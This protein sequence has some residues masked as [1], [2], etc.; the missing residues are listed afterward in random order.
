M[1][2]ERCLG[3]DLGG[4]HL[5]AV[6]LG[7][8]GGV[9][10]VRQVPCPLWQGLD[11]LESAID[12]VLE[13][14]PDRATRHAVTMTGELTDLFENRAQGV[15]ALVDRMQQRFA[16]ESIQVYAGP[17]GLLDPTA[18]LREVH[19]VAS[20]NWMASA[21]L[22]ATLL[23]EGLLVD[24]GS[25]TTDL[26]PFGGGQ[27]I[28]RGYHD[29][30]RLARGEL[31]YS[32]V[33][34][35]PVMALA[36]RVPFGGDWVPLMAEHFATTADLYRLTGDLPGHA[37]LMPSADGRPKTPVA[38]AGRLARQLGLDG[39]A[40]DPP[41]WRRLAGVL[42]EVQLRTLADACN[43]LYSRG[44]LTADAPVLGAGVGRFLA[45]RLAERLGRAYQS[46]ATLFP[47][48]PV[49]APDVGD[50][51]PAAAVAR[52]AMA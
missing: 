48:A 13:G 14:I 31:I 38:S 30:E 42:A 44:E 4:A 49:G 52:L 26:V 9:E 18:A 6:Q 17:A 21:T 24:I 7:P 39:S 2:P 20:A 47:E 32:G 19:Q 27:V 1:P 16:G 36:R 33:V 15:R 25:T 23:P 46:F 51:A 35:T 50:C 29:H 41:A 5:K 11:R 10:T 43:C 3:W 34:R 40:A 12:A 28:A 22:A 45:R 37:D 8:R